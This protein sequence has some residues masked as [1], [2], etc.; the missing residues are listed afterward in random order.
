[1]SPI[2]HSILNR[3][4][5]STARNLTTAKKLKTPLKASVVIL[6]TVILSSCGSEDSKSYYS[7]PSDIPTSPNNAGDTGATGGNTG[8][9]V[10]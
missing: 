5:L 8:A 10:G 1:M 6:T 2:S 4:A 7:A 3:S 9:T